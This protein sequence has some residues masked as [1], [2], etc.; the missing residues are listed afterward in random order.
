MNNGVEIPSTILEFRS[1]KRAVIEAKETYYEVL[2]SY[3]RYLDSEFLSIYQ[4]HILYHIGG[5]I[6]KNIIAKCS[7]INCVKMLVDEN[8]FHNYSKIKFTNP[9]AFTTFISR[10]KLKFCSSTVF[11]IMCC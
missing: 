7:C 2:C 4:R 8:C 10:G 5:Y 1:E 6:V 3:A 11:E 9:N